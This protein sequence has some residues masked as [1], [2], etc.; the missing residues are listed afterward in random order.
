VTTGRSPQLRLAP[1]RRPPG[2]IRVGLVG[3]GLAG[4]VFHAP[5]IASTD[6]LQ[7]TAIVSSNRKRVAQAE[8][9]HP[10]ATVLPDVDALLAGRDGYDLVVVACINSAHVSVAS[11]VL[12]AG[13]PVVVDKPLAV[14]SHDAQ[15]LVDL[16]AK[17]GLLL[18]AFQNRRY[19]SDQRT[20][21]R[22]QDSGE[23]GTVLRYESRFE[24][25]RPALA[26]GKW[27]ETTAATEGGGLL[28]DLGS[29]VVDQAVALFGPVTH[30]YGEVDARRGSADDDVFVALRH[31]SGVHSHLWVSSMAAAPGPRLRVL[32][33]KGAYVVDGLDGQEDALRAGHTPR[34]PGWGEEP[35]QRWGR[36]L[37][38]DQQQPVPSERGAWDAFYPAVAAALRD[39]TPPP[40]DPHD[41]IDVLR[42]LEAARTSAERQQVITL[43]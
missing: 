29:H 4:R 43:A 38:G 9:D 30:V 35:P 16:A 27:R 22:L 41:A 18:S 21:R 10:N 28:L 11:A 6:D 34:D 25:W 3:Y 33:S 19:D 39:G 14:T 7:L 40:V 1:H 15:S 23:L 37:R 13:L 42:I 26:A 8:V 17:N 5:L 12:R 2:P 32:G 24:R 20:L 31:A 36:L